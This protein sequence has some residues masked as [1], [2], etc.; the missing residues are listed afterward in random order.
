MRSFARHSDKGYHKTRMILAELIRG[1]VN[2]KKSDKPKK[3]SDIFSLDSID[4]VI[5]IT[6]T[7]VSKEEAASVEKLGFTVNK[8]FIQD[9]E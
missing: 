2:Y 8:G 9:G 4:I 5:N 1:N 6:K 7:L 3:D